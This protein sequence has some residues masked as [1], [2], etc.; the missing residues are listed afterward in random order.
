MMGQPM[1]DSKQIPQSVHNLRKIWQQKKQE[2]Q[3]T[4]VQAAKDLNWSQGAIS[5]YLS[6]ITDLGPSAIIKFANFLDVDPTEI[7]PDIEDKLP[8]VQRLNLTYISNDMTQPVKDG[9]YTRK[10][11][12]SSYVRLSKNARIENSSAGLAVGVPGMDN[13]AQICAVSKYPAA[14]IYAVRLKKEKQLRFYFKND[15]PPNS[16]VHKVWAVVSFF[17]I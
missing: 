2:M 10:N 15:L 5:H 11:A 6:N 16:K 12:V 4:Q 1:K 17:C 9:V 13:I 3:F 8:Y 14:K 7:D